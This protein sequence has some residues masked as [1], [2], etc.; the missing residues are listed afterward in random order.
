M[1]GK[2]LHKELKCRLG[3]IRVIAVHTW[4]CCLVAWSRAE[5]FLLLGFSLDRDWMDCDMGVGQG[6]RPPMGMPTLLCVLDAT[7]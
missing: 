7:W 1:C 2:G 4:P 6:R 5:I 3:G